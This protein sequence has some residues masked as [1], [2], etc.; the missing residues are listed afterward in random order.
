VFDQLAIAAVGGF[1][2]AN[3]GVIAGLDSAEDACQMYPDAIV[4]RSSAAPEDA[5]WSWSSVT[6]RG[7]HAPDGEANIFPQEEH[8][9][10]PASFDGVLPGL[11]D[12]SP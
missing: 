6:G 12:G 2:P 10:L 3:F 5:D 4:L 7:S 1:G 9:H 11:D 8:K